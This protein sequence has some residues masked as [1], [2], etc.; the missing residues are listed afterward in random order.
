[1][2]RAS[3]EHS[4]SFTGN[5]SPVHTKPRSPGVFFVLV[6]LKA[7]SQRYFTLPFW[8]KLLEGKRWQLQGVD[9]KQES[10]AWSHGYQL[11]KFHGMKIQSFLAKDAIAQS[12]KGFCSVLLLLAAR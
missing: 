7:V 11:Q 10:H 9:L 8:I 2:T 5:C 3:F 4:S 6:E 1:M 12:G